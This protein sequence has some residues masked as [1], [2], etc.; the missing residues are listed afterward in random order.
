MGYETRQLGDLQ[1]STDIALL[2]T[3]LII[4]DQ[5]EFSQLPFIDEPEVSKKNSNGIAET[6]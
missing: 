5:I 3:K 1:M 4:E 6:V 2:T